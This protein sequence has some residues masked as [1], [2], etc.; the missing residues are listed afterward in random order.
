[1]V[2]RPSCACLIGDRVMQ[3]GL[4]N[5]TEGW[6]VLAQP[7]ELYSGNDAIAWGRE[8]CRGTRCTKLK[9]DGAVPL[10][11]GPVTEGQERISVDQ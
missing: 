2:L 1:M 8:C 10:I 3:L 9:L 5:A 6:G 7:L 4:S 11:C